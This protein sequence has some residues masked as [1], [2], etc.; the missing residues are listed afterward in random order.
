MKYGVIVFKKTENIGDDIQSYAAMKQL[1][2]IDYFIEREELDTFLPSKDEY[3]KVIMG[4]WYL[5]NYLNFPPSPFIDPLIIS[6]HFTN[7]LKNQIPEYLSNGGLDYLK[8]YQPI[9]LRDSVVKKYLD[10]AGIE[11]YFSGCLTLTIDAFKIKK[12]KSICVVDVSREIEKKVKKFCEKENVFFEKYTHKINLEENLKLSYE[13]RFENVEKLLKNYQKQ[14]LV[15]TTRLHC[16]LPCLAMGV[17]VLYIY[18]SKNIDVSNRL[19]EYIDLL[20]FM[21]EKEFLRFKGSNF[22]KEIPSKNNGKY[23]K[24]REDLKSRCVDF[25]TKEKILKYEDNI[26]FYKKYYIVKKNENFNKYVD[27]NEY[28]KL[29]LKFANFEKNTERLLE[30]E[31]LYNHLSLEN[32][33]LKAEKEFMSAVLYDL[34]NQPIPKYKQT[35][36]YRGLRKIYRIFIKRGD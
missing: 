36:L 14:Q 4:G 21:S 5:H 18:D 23:L 29:L 35:I 1:P 20:Y 31:K 19:S 32:E 13:S 12:S 30:L 9:G 8:Q 16:A 17:P 33:G 3:V 25:I 24:Y 11:N 2:K 26:Y 6:A 15:I 7:H 34:R 22:L 10:E 27:R 28:Q